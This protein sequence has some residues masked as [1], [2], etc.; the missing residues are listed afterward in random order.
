VSVPFAADRLTVLERCFD[1][2]EA[3]FELLSF[4]A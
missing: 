1:G 4:P 2:A 3:L